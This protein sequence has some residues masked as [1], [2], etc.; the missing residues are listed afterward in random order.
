MTYSIYDEICQLENKQAT[1]KEVRDK[2]IDLGIYG[3]F[4]YA[5]EKYQEA[6]IFKNVVYF[7]AHAYSWESK[8]I[9]IGKDWKKCK[10]D[11]A[12]GVKLPADQ[13]GDIIEMKD[14]EMAYTMSC[15]MNLY[16]DNTDFV[17]VQKIKDL[18]QRII[19]MGTKFNA[20]DKGNADLDNNFTNI[21]R[22]E[23]LLDKIRKHE[24]KIKSEYRKLTAPEEELSSV[25]PSNYRVDSLKVEHS[26]FIKE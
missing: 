22:A 5:Y 24:M 20:D 18:Y 15:F 26:N 8:K 19:E 6:G 25:L 14:Q 10:L 3:I 7:V 21:K 23:E 13:Y 1:N 9:I 16:K 4:S 11:I 2:L 17:H 12:A